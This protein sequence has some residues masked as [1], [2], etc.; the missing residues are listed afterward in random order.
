GSG[1]R[2]RDLRLR[3]LVHDERARER[4][5]DDDRDRP[6]RAVASWRWWRQRRRMRAGLVRRIA[7]R[8]LR[9]IHTMLGTLIHSS[10]DS[11]LRA[12]RTPNADMSC[13]RAADRLKRA[14]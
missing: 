2:A 12:H 5:Q 8:V 4:E 11:A 10:V 6:R 9:R 1:G 7:Q 14:W 13:A 3:S